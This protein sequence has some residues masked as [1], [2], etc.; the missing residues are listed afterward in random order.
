M[1]DPPEDANGDAYASFT[2]RSSDRDDIRASRY[3]MTL[4]VDSVPDVTQASVTPTPRS[5]RRAGGER[6]NGV[7]GKETRGQRR[8]DASPDQRERA[9]EKTTR[10]GALAVGLVIALVGCQATQTRPESDATQAQSTAQAHSLYGQWQ[11]SWSGGGG[12]IGITIRESGETPEVTYCFKGH[13]WDPGDVALDGATLT[14]TAQEGNL[15]YRFEPDDERLRATLKR[16]GRTFRSKMKRVA[17]EEAA[18]A[19][20]APQTT[21]APAA[22]PEPAGLAVMA[23]HW[24]GRWDSGGKSTLTV[25]GDTPGT[26][27]VEYCY[28]NE[29]RSIEGYTF[30]DGTLAWTNR[31]WRFE[32]TLKGERVRG[33]LT[34]PRGTTRIS[35]KRK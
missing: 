29:C 17:S 14:F 2:F 7:F 26:M 9:M 13:C 16:G 8:R 23:G 19:P 18:P 25:T 27:A 31:G 5:R 11:G 33:K 28:N 15:R 1:Y 35:M 10:R 22:A 30:E 4:D 21:S 12:K 3:T 32:F 34:N 24:S 6:L 20:E